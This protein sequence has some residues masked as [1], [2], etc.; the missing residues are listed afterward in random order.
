MGRGVRAHVE[1]LTPIGFVSDLALAAVDVV[2]SGWR[3][4]NP[5]QQNAAPRHGPSVRG[6]AASRTQRRLQR[7][8]P[9]VS[10]IA[11]RRTRRAATQQPLSEASLLG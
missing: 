7:H 3:R 6:P 4:R 11:G 9:P 5:L 2:G 8:R 1:A 10:R